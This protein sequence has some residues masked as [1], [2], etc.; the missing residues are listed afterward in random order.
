ML[1]QNESRG[2]LLTLRE[3]V[4]TPH[5]GLGALTPRLTFK[6]RHIMAMN[7]E[8][9]EFGKQDPHQ[10][11]LR[12]HCAVDERERRLKAKGWTGERFDRKFE[13]QQGLC[14]VCGKPMHKK[15]GLDG[16]KACTDHEH[17]E[18]PKP[19]GLLCINCN[20]GLGNFKDN[21]QFLLQAV[22]YILKYKESSVAVQRR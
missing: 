15:K 9:C 10:H 12:K 16:N 22:A 18:P 4:F 3:S 14:A 19:R 21:P 11:Q 8:Q 6:G 20:A 2:T 13:E 17:T 5:L 1:T 7:I